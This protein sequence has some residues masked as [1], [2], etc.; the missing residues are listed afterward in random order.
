MASPPL[1]EH[2]AWDD[3]CCIRDVPFA[4]KD[5]MEAIHQIHWRKDNT[6]CHVI[7]DNIFSRYR[8]WYR[9][10]VQLNCIPTIMRRFNDS[11]KDCSLIWIISELSKLVY[12]RLHHNRI[13]HRKPTSSV[14]LIVHPALFHESTALAWRRRILICTYCCSGLIILRSLTQ[15]TSCIARSCPWY[16]FISHIP[17]LYVCHIWLSFPVLLPFLFLAC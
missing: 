5:L 1:P 11:G 13:Q 17:R 10:S 4:H 12:P 14:V 2:T 7:Y 3:H 16:S 6:H 8:F 15:S 9:C